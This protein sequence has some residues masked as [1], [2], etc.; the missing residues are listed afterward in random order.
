MNVFSARVWGRERPLPQ[1]NEQSCARV[2]STQAP[3]VTHA[4]AQQPRF[5]FPRRS[6]S[7]KNRK[8]IYTPNVMRSAVV[9]SHNSFCAWDQGPHASPA[10]HHLCMRCKRASCS[11]ATEKVRPS[12]AVVR[13]NLW[14]RAPPGV[15]QPG[16]EEQHTSN[17]TP[18]CL[19]VT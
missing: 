5:A 7:C 6:P 9:A 10:R 3:G 16:P 18:S 12:A 4:F 13:A 8:I 2:R 1:L 14:L 19:P 15:R 17:T 11:P